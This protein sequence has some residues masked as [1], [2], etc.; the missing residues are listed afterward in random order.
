MGNTNTL[1]AQQRALQ[2][3]M[4]EVET[5]KSSLR[6][7]LPKTPKA[8]EAAQRELT[9]AEVDQNMVTELEDLL[10]AKRRIREDQERV[11][12]ELENM[13]M[14]KERGVDTFDP[15]ELVELNRQQR[16]RHIDAIVHGTLPPDFDPA[17]N[18]W[19]EEEQRRFLHNFPSFGSR[20]EWDKLAQCVATRSESE[21]REH[22]D[23]FLAKRHEMQFR[24]VRSG[25]NNVPQPVP[26]TP[27]HEAQAQAFAQ[28]LS[29]MGVDPD[30]EWSLDEQAVLE[31]GLKQ[32]P[33]SECITTVQRYIKIAALLE[34]KLVRDVAMRFKWMCDRYDSRSPAVSRSASEKSLMA[35][36]FEAKSDGGLKRDSVR[37]TPNLAERDDSPSGK[38]PQMSSKKARQRRRRKS[39]DMRRESLPLPVEKPPE[40]SPEQTSK[41]L[42]ENDN[43]L[44]QM[45]EILM[46]GN[47]ARTLSPMVRFHANMATV[48]KGMGPMTGIAGP[49]PPLRLRVNTSL[50]AG[51]G[52][53]ASFVIAP[54]PSNPSTE[55]PVSAG[56]RV[57]LTGA[58]SADDLGRGSSAMDTADDENNAGGDPSRLKEQLNNSGPI[59]VRVDPVP[60]DD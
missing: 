1:L 49:L 16:V 25:A 38:R 4:D 20:G 41:M 5:L 47:L 22:A 17:F 31:E 48:L 56:G 19:T 8:I 12:R 30:V 37:S 34:N 15:E 18:E 26:T 2:T 44:K 54:D 35:D 10:L 24:P 42:D 7:P 27:I 36:D 11:V 60:I 57:G 51:H 9:D 45:K 46:S 28:R 23:I 39:D 14:V 32:F 21:V 58:K 43:C 50:L 29:N 59:E 55:P 3:R 40:L 33:L 52:D 13:M 6:Q 53:S